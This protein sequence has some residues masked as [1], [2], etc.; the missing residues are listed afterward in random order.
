MSLVVSFLATYNYFFLSFVAKG[1]A[2]LLGS[3]DYDSSEA[4]KDARANMHDV[5]KRRNMTL[6]GN[7]LHHC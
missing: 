5:N 1:R 6:T 3:D 7:L 2:D 4:L